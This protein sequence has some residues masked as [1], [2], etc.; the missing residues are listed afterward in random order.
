MAANADSVKKHLIESLKQQ[1][2]GNVY[3]INAPILVEFARKM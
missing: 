1:I 3:T 2:D